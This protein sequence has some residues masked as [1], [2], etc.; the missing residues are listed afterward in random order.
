MIH[1]QP[2]IDFVNH[3]FFSIH[4]NLYHA[5]AIANDYEI[6]AIGVSN[7]DGHGLI[8]YGSEPSDR[9]GG[10]GP[11]LAQETRVSLGVLLAEAKTLARGPRGWIRRLAGKP[12]ARRFGAE[13]RRLQR[14]KPRLLCFSIMRKRGDSPFQIP[15]QTVYEDAVE[16]LGLKA[17]YGLESSA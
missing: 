8:S 3:G 4:P 7:R 2:F 11:I 10:L 1:A 13:I 6:I 9:T 5:L 17:E 16:D 14:Q 12:E 15:I